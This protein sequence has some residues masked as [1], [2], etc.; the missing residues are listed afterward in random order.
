MSLPESSNKNIW[1][2]ISLAI[3]TSLTS[4]GTAFISQGSGED[5]NST[6]IAKIELIKSEVSENTHRSVMSYAALTPQE[7]ARG[8]KIISILNP[9]ESFQL[10]TMSYEKDRDIDSL[11]SEKT[12]KDKAHDVAEKSE[13]KGRWVVAKKIVPSTKK[14]KKIKRK[15]I[16]METRHLDISLV[17]N[18][19]FNKK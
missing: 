12:S 18:V 14:K 4:L 10:E 5:S 16:T 7:I 9:M 1:L 11:K 8:R 3:I 19:D 2:A 13:K 6:V 17:K 15:K